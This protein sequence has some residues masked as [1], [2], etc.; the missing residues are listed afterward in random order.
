M[1]EFPEALLPFGFESPGD[2]P[3]F[4]FDRAIAPFG[5]VGFVTGA[6]N[7]QTPLREGGVVIG[8]PLLSGPQSG[9]QARRLQGFQKG[10]GHRL[11]N[12]QAAYMEAI[13]PAPVD[14][15]CPRAV[16]TR[17]GVPAA[18]VGPEAT[19]AM[20]AGGQALQ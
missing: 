13:D 14:D 20:A 9:L 12:L 10:L 6:L 1:I 8:F 5:F 16:V 7:S 18:I 11:I 17:G 15:V 2:Q 19:A 3:V 4:G